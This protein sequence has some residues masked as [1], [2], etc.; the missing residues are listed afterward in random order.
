VDEEFMA[1]VVGR[2]KRRQAEVGINASEISRRAGRDPSVVHD[3]LSGRNKKP[4]I[5]LMRDIAGALQTSVGYLIGE[6]AEPAQNNPTEPATERRLQLA[7]ETITKLAAL[8]D[9]S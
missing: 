3:I 9:V 8:L 7:K 1:A 5:L 4:A 2:I 6:M